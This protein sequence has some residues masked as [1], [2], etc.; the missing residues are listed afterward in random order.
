MLCPQCRQF[1]LVNGRPSA[2]KLS[3]TGSPKR[4]DAAGHPYWAPPHLMGQST[5]ITHGY[6][7]APGT[8][9]HSSC[10][11]RVSGTACIR[12]DSAK[13]TR[14]CVAMDARQHTAS[15]SLD[16]DRAFDAAFERC[17]WCSVEQG[18]FEWT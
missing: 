14:G 6:Q 8:Q 16:V 2:H 5:M 3:I 11:I 17:H 9:L 4:A 13:G 18:I 15:A 7:R 1:V 12:H 10:P